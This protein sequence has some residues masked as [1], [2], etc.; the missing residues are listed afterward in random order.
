MLSDPF[1]GQDP[2]LGVMSPEE[3]PLAKLIQQKSD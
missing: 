2:A 1:T 3:D